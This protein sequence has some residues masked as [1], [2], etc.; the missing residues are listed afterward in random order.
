MHVKIV[1][2]SSPRLEGFFSYTLEQ[3]KMIFKFNASSKNACQKFCQSSP[4]LRRFFCRFLHLMHLNT[5]KIISINW[6]AFKCIPYELFAAQGLL[7]SICW[8]TENNY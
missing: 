6:N 7:V 3:P 2:E 1:A 4:R 5:F 8:K